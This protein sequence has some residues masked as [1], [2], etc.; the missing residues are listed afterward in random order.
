MVA[1]ILFVSAFVIYLSQQDRIDDNGRWAL[2]GVMTIFAIAWV[3]LAEKN[4]P[5]VRTQVKAVAKVKTETEVVEDEPEEEESSEDGMSLRERKL[6]K[7][8]SNEEQDSKEDDADDD[9]I[10]E[11]E[12]TVENLHVAETF[13]VEVSPQS[14]EDAEI[15]G[16]LREK[17]E[18]DKKIRERIEV[19]RRGRMAEIRASTARMW[20]DYAAGEDLL[21]LLAKKGHGQEVLSEPENVESGGIYGATFVRLNDSRIL[22]IRT[23]LTEGFITLS[24]PISEE[25]APLTL[26]LPPI[27]GG[28]PLPPLPGQMPL[29]LPPPPAPSSALASLKD[30]MAADD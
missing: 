28:M 9:D 25:D 19:R 10:P 3:L 11:V 5:A 30:E 22:K 18:R 13:A 2:V 23:S 14:I 17:N 6:A 29:P 1:G 24:D 20:E 26:D 12:V 27:P 15:D 4:A 16:R 7:I 8:R 21:A